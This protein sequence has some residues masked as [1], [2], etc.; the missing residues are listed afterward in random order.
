MLKEVGYDQ[1]FDAQRHFR[2]LLDAMSRP[3]KIATLNDVDLEC[4]AGLTKAETLIA[5]ALLN[6]DVG[7]CVEG[8]AED[9][10]TYLALN[11]NAHIVDPDEA[12]FLF[13]SGADRSEAMMEAKIGDPR[14]PEGGATLVTRVQSI[15]SG[16]TSM[17]LEGPGVDGSVRLDV[18]GLSRSFLDDRAIKNEEFPIGVDVILVDRSDR[19]V[20]LPRTTKVRL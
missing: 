11:T 13:V 6:A 14:Y 1:V 18:D 7:F 4:P 10:E 16:T 5:F 19:V 9:A 8:L 20:C 15:G 3:G 12:D 17:T 2:V